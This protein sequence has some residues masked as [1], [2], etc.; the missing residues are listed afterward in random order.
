[1]THWMT[2]IVE[3]RIISLLIRHKWRK[4]RCPVLGGS[5]AFNDN[6]I[7][8]VSKKCQNEVKINE[9]FKIRWN[10]TRDTKKSVSQISGK[11]RIDEDFFP[12]SP[13]IDIGIFI[14]KYR[15]MTSDVKIW[16]T[17]M[18]LISHLYVMFGKTR[19]FRRTASADIIQINVSNMKSTRKLISYPF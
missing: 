13:S 18:I 8:E 9:N 10:W 19:C 11:I 7:F 2:K 16:C 5:I 12:I 14:G 1:M 4:K 3:S 17:H 6:Q 15:Q